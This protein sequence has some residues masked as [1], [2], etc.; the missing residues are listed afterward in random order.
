MGYVLLR[1]P[2]M[3][4]EPASV[5]GAPGKAWEHVHKCSI[6]CELGRRL[7]S[8]VLVKIS[9]N[10]NLSFPLDNLYCGMVEKLELLVLPS[11]STKYERCLD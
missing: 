4:E 11:A 5:P 3:N 9:L 8:Q 6:A 10:A 2:P 7:M 1:N